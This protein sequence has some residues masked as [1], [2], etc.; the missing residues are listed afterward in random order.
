MASKSADQAETQSQLLA[1]ILAIA[2]DVIIAVDESQQIT[3]F[4]NRAEEIFGYQRAEI[5]GQPVERLMPERFRSRH[6]S[7]VQTFGDGPVAAR[8][9]GERQ[10]IYGVRKS[11]EEF[12][13]EAS[14][15][16]L[17]LGG[18]RTYTIVL[19]DVSTRKAAEKALR[20]SEERLRLSVAAGHI[21]M[22]EHDHRS[23][24]IFWSPLFREILG[25]AESA[26]ASI[27][28]YMSISHPDD[29]DLVL[30]NVARAQD[31]AGSG[32]YD[33]EHRVVMSDGSL[34][35]VTINAQTYFSQDGRPVRTVGALRNITERRLYLEELEA[36]VA[37]RTKELREEIQQRE[38]AQA[39]LVQS[40]RMEAL[41]QL[42]GGIAHDSNNLLT[43]I[44]GN[45]E[46]I[47]DE[48]HGHPA[49]KYLKEA[50]EAAHMGARLNQ[51]LLMFARRRKLESKA[52]NLNDHVLTLSELL[53]R[54]IGE[55]VDLTTNLAH[56]LWPA[57]VDP[58]EI[59]NAILNLAI[60]ARDAMP[61]GGSLRVETQNCVISN[62]SARHGNGPAAG[63]YVR[64][65]VSD[66]GSGMPPAVLARCFEPFFT[67]KDQGK[68]TGLGLSM[69]YGFAKQSNGHVAI[70]SEL[71]RGTTV[72]VF[73]PREAGRRSSRDAVHDDGGVIPG[74]GETILVVEDNGQVRALTV[75]RLRRLG[76]Q[77]TEAENGPRALA[78]LEAAGLPNLVFSDVVM[79]GGMSGF[80]VA[81][82]VWQRHPRQKILLTSGFAEK[83]APADDPLFAD[84]TILRKPYSLADLARAIAEVLDAP[85]KP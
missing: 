76:Y 72:D 36:R 70:S 22:F 24:Q 16:R 1:G 25:V 73:L 53:R 6:A 67:T 64:L 45:L 27:A 85:A 32:I 78:V 62:E 41:G 43:V 54:T 37:E 80:D 26:P 44:L 65:S 68:G 77:V 51:R 19:R 18:K 20:N 33:L 59:E 81:R 52:I 17:V 28:T 3:I 12:P 13:A 60:N 57:R 15:S 50:E 9:M 79:P 30:K 75:A 48:L 21:G 4:N 55:G 58:S 56:D 31:S 49:M 8:Q 2:A 39:A 38:V 29:H 46:L 34:R 35:W 71:G 82:A 5:I 61:D 10:E 69:L 47:E 14:I 7:H 83:L 40:Q 11:G 42:T 23:G 74:R 63:D 84:S 66:S